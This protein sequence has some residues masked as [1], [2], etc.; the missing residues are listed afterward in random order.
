M[1]TWAIALISAAA[2]LLGA[3]VGGGALLKIARDDR[4]ERRD[5]EHTAALVALY[6]AA[7]RLGLSFQMWSDLQPKHDNRLTRARLGIQLV[8]FD[9]MIL[10][11]FWS[12]ADDIWLSSGRARAA[13]TDEERKVIDEVE[14]VF[15]D[16]TIGEPLP[17][18]WGPSIRRL[19]A[20]IEGRRVSD[21]AD[22]LPHS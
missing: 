16:W 5:Q 10:N 3:A 6:A 2:A 19:R 9:K 17:E 22:A 7:N 14:I 21:L 13:A 18:A 1:A 20:L 8:G 15:G 12:A 11:R 4:R